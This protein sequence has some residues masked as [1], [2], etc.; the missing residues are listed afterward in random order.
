MDHAPSPLK[1]MRQEN[2]SRSTERRPGQIPEGFD[3]AENSVKEANF[4]AARLG[5]R[6]STGHNDDG[7][8]CRSSICSEIRPPA[9][10][11][12]AHKPHYCRHSWVS[13]RRMLFHQ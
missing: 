4:E 7:D 13:I 9:N 3:L 10:H 8:N 2:K 6:P 12:R 11:I 1:A 5:D